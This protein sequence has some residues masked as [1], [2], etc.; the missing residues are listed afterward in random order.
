MLL[1][2]PQISLVFFVVVFF[3]FLFN[4]LWKEHP[5]SLE[6]CDKADHI[7]SGTDY[8]RRACGDRL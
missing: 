4:Q 6:L 1:F 8:R 2:I 7:S 5:V 3:T